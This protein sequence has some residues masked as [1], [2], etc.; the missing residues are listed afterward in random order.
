MLDVHFLPSGHSTLVLCALCMF[1]TLKTESTETQT[2][3]VTHNFQ[4]SYQQPFHL[5]A[6]LHAS[7][8]VGV[9]NSCLDLTTV[10]PK[11]SFSSTVSSMQTTVAQ[12]TI[13]TE[14]FST[15]GTVAKDETSL[16]TF[17]T[18]SKVWNMFQDCI[19]N[20]L[21]FIINHQSYQCRWKLYSTVKQIMKQLR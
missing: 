17:S 5:N 14:S 2:K 3:A 18:K 1:V 16:A 15:N 9:L 19:L 10:I 20:H 7:A 12:Q 4:P 11:T 6:D 8:H 13:E 21:Y